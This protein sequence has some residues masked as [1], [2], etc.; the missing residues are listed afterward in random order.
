MKNWLAKHAIKNVWCQPSSD[1]RLIVKPCRL[2]NRGGDIFGLT[3]SEHTV[4][5]PD[6]ENWYNVFQIGLLDPTEIGMRMWG[7]WKRLDELLNTF[8]I[9]ILLYDISGR[10]FPLSLAYARILDNGNFV[11]ATRIYEG[12][13]DF[14]NT[15]LWVR[16]YA[17][18]FLQ[19]AGYNDS[20]VS[21]T[22]SAVMRNGADIVSMLTSY[23]KVAAKPGY[24]FCYINGYPVTEL[25]SENINVWDYVEFIHDGLVREVYRFKASSLPTYMSTLDKMKKFLLHPPKR[26]EHIDYTNDLEV[27]IYKGGVGRHYATHHNSSMRQLTHRDWAISTQRVQDMITEIDDWT[28]LSQLTVAVYIRRSGLEKP[29][30]FEN[31]R[32]HELYKLSDAKIVGAM[33]GLNA[34]LPI[35]QAANLEKSDYCRMMSARFEYITRD[36]ATKT[37]GYNAVSKAVADTT[38]PVVRGDG[39]PYVRL[40]ALLACDC[41]VFEY[42]ANRVLLGFYNHIPTN[43]D[44]YY[45]NNSNAVIVEAVVGQGGDRLSIDYDAADYVCAEGFNHRFF[46]EQIID[47]KR[48]GKFEDVTG[49]ADYTVGEDG[50]VA[51]SIETDRRV[52]VIWKDD[53]FL[54]YS[55]IENAYDGYMEFSVQTVRSDTGQ[56]I[57]VPACM[58]CTDVDVWMNGR[59][60]IQGLDYFVDWP[61]IVICNKEYMGA[62]GEDRHYPTITVRCRNQGTAVEAASYG[63]VI[64]GILSDNN[65]FDVRDDKVVRIIGG[66]K[67]LSRSDVVFRE[68]AAIGTSLLPNGTPYS[69]SSPLVPLRE[70]V[71]GDTYALRKAAREIDVSVENYL[72]AIYPMPILSK[73]NPIEKKHRL[74]SPFLNRIIHDLI[75]SILIVEE[76][77]DTNYLSTQRLEEIV[78]PYLYLL[79]YDPM[80]QGV[81][82]KYVEVHPHDGYDVIVLSPLHYSIVARLNERYLNDQ[83]ILNNLLNI[84][85]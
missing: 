58:V 53:K 84:K 22:K 19:S 6:Q 45:C 38:L 8:N 43:N 12:L 50:T 46:T 65:R 2:S 62:N 54:C 47:G 5:L 48:T 7:G 14:G 3:I 55:F 63:Y 15:D 30:V 67:L 29:L 24:T 10:T 71:T 61:K 51:W 33:V 77:P 34:T 80:L 57:P 9:Q 32:I 52:P 75:N 42:D 18:H 59:P 36:T 76:D 82:L 21:S 25:T 72:S 70:T 20:Y 49:L 83:V 64:N 40:P 73:D 13:S 31:S 16:F 4:L 41:T 69:I 11:L 79:K 78:T 74:F 1:A 35:W 81:D 27:Q 28:D 68:D 44:I 26:S 60:L 37:F 56:K 85:E 17:G 23:Q 66:G 39:A